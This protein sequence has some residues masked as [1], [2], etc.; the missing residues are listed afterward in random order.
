[1]LVAARRSSSP[2]K[3][4]DGSWQGPLDCLTTSRA[5][6]EIVS[7]QERGIAYPSK[8]LK[9]CRV[10]LESYS[11]ELRRDGLIVSA[12]SLKPYKSF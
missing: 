10:A 3:C 1:M 8:E 2:R 5:L 4:S 11:C 7:A 6:H 12:A 9:A